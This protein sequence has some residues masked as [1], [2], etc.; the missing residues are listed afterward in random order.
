MSEIQSAISTIGN[1]I[2]LEKVEVMEKIAMMNKDKL[3]PLTLI[4]IQ[5]GSNGVTDN[6]EEIGELVEKLEAW[7]EDVVKNTLDAESVA[8]AKKTLS[9][10][11]KFLIET[12]KLQTNPLKEIASHFTQH[13]VK[14]KPMNEKLTAK[15][16]AIN[17]T[18]Y[19][20]RERAIVEHFES[21]LKADDLTEVISLDAFKDFIANKRKT[22]IFTSTGKLNKGIKDAVAEALRL[23]VEPIKQAKELEEKKALQSK[24]FESYLENIVADGETQMLEA[25]I[26]QLV[27]M[28]ETVSELYP[29]I[30]EHCMR[31]ID[32]KISRCESNIKANKAIE[33]KDAVK[34]AD[35]EMMAIF[36]EIKA[37][38]QD[39]TLDVESLKELG[40]QLRGIFPKLT[41]A[42]NQERVKALG[43]SI[44]QRVVDLEIQENTPVAEVE[45]VAETEVI[46]EAE[47][48]LT[49]KYFISIQDIEFIANVGIDANNEV[50]AKEKFTELFRNHL[51]MVGLTKGK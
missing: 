19:Q 17:E 44:N 4:D 46:L 27:R 41:F 11:S 32:N 5:I 28:K 1:I 31:S 2:G 37:K 45:P 40:N 29:D 3:Y 8:D 34:N 42:D 22:N 47:Y 24:Q 35:G 15:F 14:F 43:V 10:I 21:R 6:A 38:S 49:A 25:N 18:E 39:M 12:R 20:N 33:E 50:E 36:D 9:E 16:E 7:V 23:V 13:E 48:K 51:N 30:Q 26:N